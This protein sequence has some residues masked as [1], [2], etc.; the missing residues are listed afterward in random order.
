MSEIV[1]Y[2]RVCGVDVAK[3]TL[4]VRILAGDADCALSLRNDDAGCARIVAVCQQH[5]VQIVV[6]EATG[7][8]Q[9]KLALAL[10]QAKLA[11]AIVNPGRIRH[12][13]LGE[14]MMAKTDKVDARIIASFA[15]KLAPKPTVLRDAQQEQLA[16][17]ATRKAQLTWAKVDEENR[18][19]QEGDA[20]A[21]V[22]IRRHLRFLQKEIERIDQQ[23]EEL[24][25]ADGTLQSKVE[26]ADSLLGVGRASATALIVH[27][28][29]L[30]SM[31][32]KQ[33]AAL[34]GL[35]PFAA[36]SGKV[37]GERHIH[38]GRSAVRCTLYMC[39][40]TAV[41]YEGKIRSFYQNL[42]QAGKCK[43]KA[44]TACMRKMLVIINARVRDTLLALKR[45][46]STGQ[47]GV[48]AAAGG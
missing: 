35:A 30:G 17:L 22:S 10:V 44:L 8:L 24:I 38:G 14:G 48:A 18:L 5:Q 28:P 45:T 19:Q 43:M 12:Y 36:D 25:T 31:T 47:V 2:Q 15:L 9:R 21:L 23:L 6:A 46:A 37:I 4:E 42:L 11:I 1:S 40:L 27:M 29:E 16:R 39:A 33:A 32:G 20:D 7:G 13:A 3:E 41:R 26:A 34:A